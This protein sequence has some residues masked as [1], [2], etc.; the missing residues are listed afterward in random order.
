MSHPVDE[1]DDPEDLGAEEPG[2]PEKSQATFAQALGIGSLV[3]AV[4]A[5]CFCAPLVL[6]ALLA[7][8][9]AWVAAYRELGAIAEGRIDP[10]NETTAIIGKVCG[11]IGVVL[12]IILG[13]LVILGFTTLLFSDVLVPGD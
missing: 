8:I 1:F 2:Y 11:I 6:V 13:G 5:P 12:S 3:C 7:G 9:G 10:S 4:V